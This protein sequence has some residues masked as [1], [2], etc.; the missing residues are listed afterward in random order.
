MSSFALL[1]CAS[2]VAMFYLRFTLPTPDQP[3]DRVSLFRFDLY[4]RR[5]SYEES[6]TK[7]LR[8]ET[9]L[10]V[11]KTMSVSYWDTKRTIKM[12]RTYTTSTCVSGAASFTVSFP[13]KFRVPDPTRPYVRS[14]TS[15]PPP[16]PT[17]WPS[18]DQISPLPK[19]LV[20]VVLQCASSFIVVHE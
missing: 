9:P 12:D 19:K 14:C 8:L 1:V 16:R 17:P 15:S 18:Y 7:D 6:T 4:Q 10:P 11:C 5:P 13:C 2:C 20:L 3:T